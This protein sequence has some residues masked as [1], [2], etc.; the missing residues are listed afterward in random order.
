VPRYD[1]HC[2]SNGR[3]VEVRHG[4][5]ERLR[6]WGEICAR[7]QEATGDTPADAPVELVVHAPALGFPRGDSELK[8][9]GFTKLVRRDTGVYENV[10]ASDGE[11]RIVSADNPAAGLNLGKKLGD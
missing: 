1:Y 5:H 11:S 9:K 6:T 10:T 8:S 3:T 2:A 7:A 4:I